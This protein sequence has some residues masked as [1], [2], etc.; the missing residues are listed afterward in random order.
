VFG[1]VAAFRVLRQRTG[2]LRRSTD[3]KTK[4]D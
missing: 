1:I 3:E 2:V 4:E